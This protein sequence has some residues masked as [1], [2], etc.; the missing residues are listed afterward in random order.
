MSINLA[1]NTII[2]IMVFLFPGIL[3]RRM[4][5]SGKFNKHFDSGNIFERVLWYL[6]LSILCISTFSFISQYFNDYFNINISGQEILDAFNSLYKFDA[7]KD[8]NIGLPDII[9]NPNRLTDTFILLIGL[10]LYSA[11]IGKILNKVI[12]ILG[13]QN[14]YTFFR[15]QSHW[16]Y[17]TSSNNQN[18]TKHKIGDVYYTKIDIKTNDNEL[19]TGNLYDI[20]IDKEG[21]VDIISVKDTYKFYKIEKNDSNTKKIENIKERIKEKESFFIL[22]YEND[23][24]ICYKKRIKGD[25]FAISQHKINNISISYIKLS[26]IKEKINIGISLFLMIVFLFSILYGIFDFG[27]IAFN[28]IYQRLFFCIMLPISACTIILLYTIF[29]VVKNNKNYRRQKFIVLLICNLLPY[30]YIFNIISF[31]CFIAIFL[32]SFI[33]IKFFQKT[34]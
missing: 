24:E 2:Y 28:S 16:D 3:F 12:F 25:I 17:L 20:T 18:N 8:K 11:C 15:F 13:L 9:I 1:I 14:R 26:D 27:I 21:K 32:T 34:K 7:N 29:F 30:L 31:Y 22:H 5:F 23:N 33:I 4:F 6:L 19:F 10:Y